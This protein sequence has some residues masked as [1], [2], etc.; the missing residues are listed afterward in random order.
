MWPIGKGLPISISF[1]RGY[2]LL[3]PSLWAPGL[4]IH[5][6]AKSTQF[7]CLCISVYER[8]LLPPDFMKGIPFRHLPLLSK[9]TVLTKANNHL[10]VTKSNFHFHSSSYLMFPW[11]I[12]TDDH[13]FPPGT[14]SSFT[15]SQTLSWSWLCSFLSGWSSVFSRDLELLRLSSAWFL[16]SPLSPQTPHTCH[17]FSLCLN[18]NAPQSR[19]LLSAS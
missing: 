3:G 16:L 18:A 12:N 11:Q 6:A 13:I 9:K 4:G 19:T 10:H 7:N 2:C 1:Y 5:T 15:F 14:I 17:N 8:A